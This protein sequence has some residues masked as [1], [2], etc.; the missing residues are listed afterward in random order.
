MLASSYS[1][2]SSFDVSLNWPGRSESPAIAIPPQFV[3][4]EFEEQ[5]ASA[6][7]SS[8]YS[9]PQFG[10]ASAPYPGQFDF[11]PSS[12][13]FVLASASA[14][15]SDQPRTV[16][17]SL[18][19]QPV[20]VS[21]ASYPHYHSATSSSRSSDGS[22]DEFSDLA[23]G[24]FTAGQQPARQLLSKRERNNLSATQYRK[25]RKEYY[26]SLE[27]KLN[28]QVEANRALR[29]QTEFLKGLI[30]RERERQLKEA[31]DNRNGGPIVANE[32]DG[33]EQAS[34]ALFVMFSSFLMFSPSRVPELA[35]LAQGVSDIPRTAQ[36]VNFL[37]SAVYQPLVE[38]FGPAM[39]R[40][41]LSGIAS[42]FAQ[43]PEEPANNN[44]RL[45]VAN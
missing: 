37:S 43:Q 14:P 15:H 39:V 10:S 16:D 38:L 30:I 26:A 19:Q 20:Q 18:A 21:P 13:G 2:F 32:A 22:V 12:Y 40:A 17:T 9:S 45:K 11:T 6:S 36:A 44:K 28:E 35:Q 3:K 23:Q 7:P 42:H 29:Q 27:S 5:P 24:Q 4:E 25:R 33:V 41:A 8:G 1:P 31:K 34:T